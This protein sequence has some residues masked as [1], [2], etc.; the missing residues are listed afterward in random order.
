MRKSE[1]DPASKGGEGESRAENR[2][3]RK[4]NSFVV[5]S[6]MFEVVAEERNGKKHAII[7]ESKGGVV[8]WVRLGPASVGLLIEGLI[9]C[10]KDGKDERW[11]KEWKEKGRL[12]S[13]VREANRVGSF[14]R[15]GVTDLEK[16]RFGICIPKGKGEKGG[17]FLWWSPYGG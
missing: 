7:S 1:G 14:I 9:Q 8:S 15:L 11:E 17:W 3:K 2:G 13:L 6:K 5:E 12:Y 10:T 16:M 4:R